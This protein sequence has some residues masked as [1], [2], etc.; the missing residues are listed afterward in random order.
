M[1]TISLET[2]LQEHKTEKKGIEVN[3]GKVTN[4]LPAGIGR[5]V[6]RTIWKWWGGK[7]F[8]I[9]HISVVCTCQMRLG[10][11]EHRRWAVSNIQ[12]LNKCIAHAVNIQDAALLEAD[13]VSEHKPK[14]EHKPKVPASLLFASWP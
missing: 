9:W 14:A 8:K 2:K 1:L 7:D 13:E 11:P 4:S 3:L 12:F 5:I 6:Q 10:V